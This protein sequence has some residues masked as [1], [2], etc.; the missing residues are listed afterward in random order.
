MEPGTE[1]SP[2][3]E[4]DQLPK[5]SSRCQNKARNHPRWWGTLAALGNLTRSNCSQPSN[6]VTEISG[7]CPP[8]VSMLRPTVSVGRSEIQEW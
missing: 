6:C 5:V 7:A 2:L 8:Q 4:E 3:L 1:G